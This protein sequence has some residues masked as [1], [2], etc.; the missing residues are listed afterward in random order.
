MLDFFLSRLSLFFVER[1]YML[2]FNSSCVGLLSPTYYRSSRISHGPHQPVFTQHSLQIVL[3]P[4]Y[5]LLTQQ[6]RFDSRHKLRIVSSLKLP[7]VLEPTNI[8]GRRLLRAK[9]AGG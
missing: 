2:I 8:P 1:D 9:A 3:R 5:G 6:S 7:A 4:G